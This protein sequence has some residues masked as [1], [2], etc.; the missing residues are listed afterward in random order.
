MVWS[1]TQSAL[2]NDLSRYCDDEKRA[3]NLQEIEPKK[4][5]RIIG[6]RSSENHKEN[7]PK[8]QC[9]TEGNLPLKNGCGNS[10]KHETAT[11]PSFPNCPNCPRRQNNMQNPL[12]RL[13]SD[14]DMLLIAGLIFLLMK[15]GADKKLI[16]ALTFVLLS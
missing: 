9:K 4:I 15:Q 16:L 11:Y 1:T 14:K 12:S 7:E 3:P 10:P 13:L 6:E 2:Y 8:K 5:D